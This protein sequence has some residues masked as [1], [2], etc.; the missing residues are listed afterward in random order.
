MAVADKI[1]RLRKKNG[2]S[3]EELAEK[4]SVSRQAVSKW[5][6]AKAV[7]DLKKILK[8]AELFGVTTDYL[9][10]DETDK[11]E[12]INTDTESQLNSGEF[13]HKHGGVRRMNVKKTLFVTFLCFVTVAVLGGFLYIRN[14]PVAYDAGACGGGYAAFVFDKY[15]DELVQKYI[16]GSDEK[17][18]IV[19]VKA[20]KG[21]QTAEW[22]DKRVFLQ[23]N[24]QIEYQS[25]ETATQSVRFTGKRKW[26]DTFDWSGARIEV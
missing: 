25:G 5:E 4:M 11:Q 6:S 10:N 26:I 16:D 18:E 1:M 24:I 3:Q 23:F 22:I 7:P 8:L 12:L 19:S 9:L 17:N 20:I 2:W 14:L 15:G 13:T 21:T